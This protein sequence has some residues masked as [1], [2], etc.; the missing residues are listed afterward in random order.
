MINIKDGK[1][2]GSNYSFAIP[3]GYQRIE[4]LDSFS[5]EDLVLASEENKYLNIVVYFEKG[6]HSAKNDIQE[7]FDKN[8]WLIKMSEPFS[9]KRGEG[10]AIGIFYENTFGATQHYIELYDFKKNEDGETQIYVD[11][12]LWSGRGED[13][14][15][16]QEAVKLPIIKAFL[17]SI[18]YF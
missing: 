1:L 6:R 11:I 16:I 3:Q 10:E 8:S 15:T 5:D 2:C 7:M 18:E 17:N 4:G 9:V 13:R 14:Q 12:S